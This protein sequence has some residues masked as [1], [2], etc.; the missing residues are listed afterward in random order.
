MQQTQRLTQGV[1]LT[2]QMRQALRILQVGAVELRQEIAAEAVANPLLEE[3]LPD[4]GANIAGG[5]IDSGGDNFLSEDAHGAES[6]DEDFFA[7]GGEL[8]ID[9]NDFSAL[10]KMEEDRRDDF[11]DENRLNYAS[12]DSDEARRYLLDSAIGEGESLQENLLAQARLA[13]PTPGVSKAFEVLV[14]NLDERGFMAEPPE[15]LTLPPDVSC[16]DLD[17]A[18]ALLKTC[19]PAGIGAADLR[20]CLLLQLLRTERGHTLAALI[21]EACFPLLLKRKIPQIAR[22]LG[23]TPEAVK[24][25]LSVIATL[26]TAPARRFAKD[27]NQVIDSPDVVIRR[28]ETGGGWVVVPNEANLPRLRIN[29]AYKNLLAGENLSDADR[30]YIAEKIR[31]GRFLI[32]AIEQRRS[33]LERVARLLLKHQPEFF[34]HGFSKLRPLTMRMLAAE[35]G[36]H[37]TTVSRTVANK[38]VQTPHGIFEL[39]SFFTSGVITDSGENVSNTGIKEMLADLVAG[40]NTAS[41]L[42]DEALCAALAGKGIKVARRT[43]AKYR[44][45]LKIPAA[46]L[47]KRF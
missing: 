47:R 23:K 15:T 10:R 13:A 42:S 11:D 36:V 22:Q 34:E 37:E 19:E 39:R 3:I 35:L 33:M 16:A 7:D 43:V 40:E 45:A 24:D 4:A 31:A 25:A 9:D 44:E 26:D 12:E 32:G 28:D 20:E 2:P 8:R 14:G 38:F 27:E 21:L 6:E 46:H 41:P 5:E 30:A 18:R 29:H 1:V 17:A